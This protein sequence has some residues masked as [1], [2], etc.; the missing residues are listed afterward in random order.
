[1]TH[2]FRDALLR[3]VL[4]VLVRPLQ[5]EHPR[6]PAELDG[7]ADAQPVVLAGE[8]ALLVVVAA[9]RRSGGIKYLFKLMKFYRNNY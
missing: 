2:Q 3:L 8:A 7:V 1:M 5:D 9:M 4:H 6:A